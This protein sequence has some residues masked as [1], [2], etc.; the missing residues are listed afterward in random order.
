M[1]TAR[2]LAIALALAVAL[3]IGTAG[4]A[5][6]D[7]L[8]NYDGGTIHLGQSL[9]VGVFY[10]HG[11]HGPSYWEGVWSVPLHRWIFQRYGNAPL[12]RWQFSYVKPTRRGSYHTVYNADGVRV[13]FYTT[14]R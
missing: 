13:T 5:K 7:V 8:V 4:A 1:K 3:A 2:K 11:G 10:K 12:E 14:V 9:R 6:A